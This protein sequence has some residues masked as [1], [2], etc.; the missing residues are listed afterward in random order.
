MLDGGCG[1]YFRLVVLFGGD[2]DL[3]LSALLLCSRSGYLNL[4]KFS[5]PIKNFSY[6]SKYF[7]RWC[8]KK[9]VDRIFYMEGL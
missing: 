1:G 8:S 5:N 7:N 4:D 9:L 2:W 3:N 6:S